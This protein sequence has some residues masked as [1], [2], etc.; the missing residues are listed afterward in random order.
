MARLEMALSQLEFALE[1]LVA[2][3]PFLF[4]EPEH[5]GTRNMERGTW[6]RSTFPASMLR[7]DWEDANHVCFSASSQEDYQESLRQG[8]RVA[9]QSQAP[10]K[11]MLL[12][13]QL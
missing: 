2:M 9:E 1:S 8:H 12:Y 6:P 11:P 13:S 5:S 4:P 3:F 7:E 10:C